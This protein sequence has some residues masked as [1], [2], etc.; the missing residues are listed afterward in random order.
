MRVCEGESVREREREKERENESSYY[1]SC[2]NH[3]SEKSE[4]SD[5]N[6]VVSTHTH[7]GGSLICGCTPEY[8]DKRERERDSVCVCVCV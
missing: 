8:K 1:R 7:T 2:Q 3:V 4:Q 5:S 6:H